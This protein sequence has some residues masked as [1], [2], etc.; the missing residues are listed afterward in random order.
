MSITSLINE[1]KIQIPNSLQELFNK[2][3]NIIKKIIL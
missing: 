2:N 1:K 3:D